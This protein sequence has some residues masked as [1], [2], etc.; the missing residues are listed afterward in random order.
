MF[1]AYMLLYILFPKTCHSAV[2]YLEEEAVKTYTHLAE[3]LKA[4]KIPEWHEKEA[5]QIAKMYWRL[6]VVPRRVPLHSVQY[7]YGTKPASD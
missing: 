7:V 1:N 4:A 6:E 3:D 2:G 5:P